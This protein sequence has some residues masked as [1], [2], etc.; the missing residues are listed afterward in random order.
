MMDMTAGVGMGS[1][2]AKVRGVDL[3]RPIRYRGSEGEMA[4]RLVGENGRRR[5]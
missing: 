2:E 5:K 1:D 4:Y 3:K